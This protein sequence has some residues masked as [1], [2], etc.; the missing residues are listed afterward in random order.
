MHRRQLLLAA[1][2]AALAG[3]VSAQGESA[4]RIVVPYAAGGS[5]DRAARLVAD[6]LGARLGHPVVVENRTGAGG[7][8]AAQQLRSANAQQNVL[9]LA[10]PAIMVVAPLVFKDNG[11]DPD[12]DFQPVSQVSDY[13][14][15]LAV[16]S[17]VPVKELSHLLAWLRANPGQANF[18]VPATGSL[19]HFFALMTGE[20]ASVKAQVV[21]YRGSAP[22]ISDLIGGQIP[23]AFDTLDT[24]LPQHEGGKLRI[25]ASSGAGRSPFA[26]HIPTYKESG[27]NLVATGWNAFFAPAAMPREQVRRLATA[28]REVMADPDTQRKFVDAKMTPVAST[29]AQTEAML[30][31]YRAQWAPVVRQSGYQP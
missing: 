27:L 30:K 29:P 20:K 14:F 15:G 24:L 2:S 22:L 25:L 17:A 4:L 21:G 11:Y 18:G 16:S 31:A 26:R 5:S 6:K 7:R 3:R 1:G 8:L 9:M 12:K 10:N 23:V 13:E 28:I 19:P